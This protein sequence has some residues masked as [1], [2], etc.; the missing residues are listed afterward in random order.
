MK[1]SKPVHHRLIKIQ[2][3]SCVAFVIFVML[4]IAVLLFHHASTNVITL[5][6]L[7]VFVFL[8]IPFAISVLFMFDESENTDSSIGDNF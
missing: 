5:L 7:S 8:L 2:D 4:M 3:N 1:L 6:I